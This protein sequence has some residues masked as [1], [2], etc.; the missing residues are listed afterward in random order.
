M[1][2]RRSIKSLTPSFM[3]SSNT[4]K[5]FPT[6]PITG[7]PSFSDATLVSIPPY[8]VEGA[9][10]FT[11]TSGAYPFMRSNWN[12]RAST[13]QSWQTNGMSTI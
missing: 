9:L 2:P 3:R 12:G 11:L 4:R 7:T 10:F 8:A 13:R 1:H 5:G 6:S